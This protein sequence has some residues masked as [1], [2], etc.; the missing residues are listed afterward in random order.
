MKERAAATIIMWIA[1]AATI[2]ELVSSVT[3]ED[4]PNGVIRPV[5]QIMPEGWQI[6]VAVLVLILAVA[7]VAGTL[8]IWRKAGDHASQPSQAISHRQSEKI[9][10]DRRQ[11]IARLLE[12]MDDEDL[13]ALEDR[14]FDDEGEII[15]IEDL[16]AD[17]RQRQV[18]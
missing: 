6:T 17:Q 11:R 9:K 8:F 4:F 18:H 10:R 1:L 2:S 16:L 15:P 3:Y 12:T 7:G 13:A 14:G 5:Q